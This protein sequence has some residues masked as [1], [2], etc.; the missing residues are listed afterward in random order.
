MAGLFYIYIY[1]LLNECRDD[2]VLC[3]GLYVENE[4]PRIL[5]FFLLSLGKLFI[6]FRRLVRRHSTISICFLPSHFLRTI[7]AMDVHAD[8][9]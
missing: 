1:I 2:D 8:L 6:L 7:N 5:F 9:I 3:H 4:P